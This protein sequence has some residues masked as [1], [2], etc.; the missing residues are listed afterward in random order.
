M[1]DDMDDEKSPEEETLPWHE[2]DWTAEEIAFVSEYLRTGSSVRAHKHA[3]P[4]HY[5]AKGLARK[6]GQDIRATFSAKTILQK[7][8]IQEYI[9]FIRSELKQ[10]MVMDSK[11]VLQELA[12]LARSNM[13]DFYIINEDGM[14]EFDLSGLTAEQSAS[15]SEMTIST[16]VDKLDP[17]NR[18]VRDVKV[19]LA[20]KTPALE[21]VGKNLKMWTDVV[22]STSKA[23]LSAIIQERRQ[24][25]RQQ[26]GQDKAPDDTDDDD[27]SET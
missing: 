26:S 1:S 17:E 6:Q 4:D 23:D 20:P 13:A 3:F 25:R 27:K 9:E 12:H 8:Y 21:L 22:E 14:P 15:I 2:H 7:P 19:K 18:F 5:A 11:S 24:K 10:C 16:S